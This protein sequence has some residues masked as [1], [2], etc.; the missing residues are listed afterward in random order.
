MNKIA[1]CEIKRAECTEVI[2][3]EADSQ[4]QNDNVDINC[5]FY[6]TLSNMYLMKCSHFN[7][8]VGNK[9][10][11]ALLRGNSFKV[12]SGRG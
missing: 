11:P 12:T 8:T 2:T 10:S 6:V 9:M 3:V 4:Q 1:S 5:A 7:R